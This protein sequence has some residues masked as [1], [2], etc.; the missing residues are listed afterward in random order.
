MCQ[1]VITQF[2]KLKPL[3]PKA[4][5]SYK[6][7]LATLKRKV[8]HTKYI[9]TGDEINKRADGVFVLVGASSSSVRL[10][11]YTITRRCCLCYCCWE[12]C[13]NVGVAAL[14]IHSRSAPNPTYL[15][16]SGLLQ[17]S[18]IYCSCTCSFSL[19]SKERTK[20]TKHPAP[21]A[22]VFE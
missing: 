8:P 22:P 6:I 21:P 4:I 17:S 10:L 14:C 12:L 1:Q 7:L 16:Q 3:T 18:R 11:S 5:H 19:F 15:E 20:R 13:V 9:S 2:Q